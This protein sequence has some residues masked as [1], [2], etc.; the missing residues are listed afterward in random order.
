MRIHLC[1]HAEAQS[2]EPDELRELTRA[3]R[4]GA[5]LLAERLASLD[6]PPRAVVTSPLTRARQTAE[7]VAERLGCDVLVRDELAP[8][9]DRGLAPRGGGGPRRPRGGRLPPA[10]LLGDHAG[11][12]GRRPRLPGRRHVPARARRVSARAAAIRVRSLRKS[13]G[14]HEAVRGIDFDVQPGEVFGLLGPNGAGK[15]TTVEILEG[16]RQRD[17]GDVEVLGVD[18]WQ[19][20]LGA[21]RADRGRPP[22]LRPARAPHGPRGALDVRG[23]L[24]AAAGRRR[25][26]RARRTRRQGGRAA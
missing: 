7:P 23:V 15:T 25:G 16:Y 11:G 1:R 19:A 17:G 24:R 8:G 10:R 22:A 14:E 26:D 13:Y 20:R 18:P 12:D 6:E 9:R 3:G 21:P 5:K 4:D 2:G